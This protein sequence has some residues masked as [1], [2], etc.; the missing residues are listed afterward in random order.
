MNKNSNNNR[1]AIARIEL[2]NEATKFLNEYQY[3]VTL[4]ILNNRTQRNTLTPNGII[5][6]VLVKMISNID[7]M[8]TK[9]SNLLNRDTK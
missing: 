8:T 4:N 9:Q 5:I 6:P 7:E 2:I 3:F 1:L